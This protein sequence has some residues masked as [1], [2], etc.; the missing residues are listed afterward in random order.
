MLLALFRIIEPVSGTIFID[1]VT[2]RKS[3]CM[4]V[5]Y[6]LVF[7]AH[8]TNLYSEIWFIYCSSIS[9]FVWRNTKRKHWSHWRIFRYQYLDCTSTSKWL[10]LLG[11]YIFSF[12]QLGTFERICGKSPRKTWCTCPWRRFIFIKWPKTT[13]VLC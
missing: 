4:T 1:S 2:L 12:V 6:N 10:S 13:V 9:R 11:S 5:S 7:V 3:D 8:Y